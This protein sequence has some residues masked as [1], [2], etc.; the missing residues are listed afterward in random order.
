MPFQQLGSQPVEPTSDLAGHAVEGKLGMMQTGLKLGWRVLGKSVRVF[1]DEDQAFYEGVIVNFSVATG[2]HEVQYVADNVREW[3]HLCMQRM[4]W[5]AADEGAA[6][7]MLGEE[8]CETKSGPDQKRVQKV[9]ARFRETRLGNMLQGQKVVTKAM[10][11]VVAEVKSAD[12]P[13]DAV[14]THSQLKLVHTEELVLAAAASAECKTVSIISKDAGE[15]DVRMQGE[16]IVNKSQQQQEDICYTLAQ[17]LG[18]AFL[19]R[20]PDPR[21][22][23]EVPESR[24]GEASPPKMSVLDRIATSIRNQQICESPSESPAAEPSGIGLRV[25]PN[26]TERLDST[27]EAAAAASH[28]GGPRVKR[29]MVERLDHAD[30]AEGLLGHTISDKNSQQGKQQ[31]V[32]A[33]GSVKVG[34]PLQPPDAEAELDK[35]GHGAEQREERVMPMQL[36]HFAPTG[37]KM[38]HQDPEL[39]AAIDTRRRYSGLAYEIRATFQQWKQLPDRR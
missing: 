32:A 31:K 28:E 25:K 16:A 34:G 19:G 3:S 39:K 22:A 1:W 5:L 7:A 35:A 15:E 38:H 9:P 26:V 37:C 6:D 17:L 2:E 33:S 24:W 27:F 23:S 14:V 18:A 30:E 10:S 8:R 29:K 21:R 36:L 20:P 4:E 13:P 12:T 11:E